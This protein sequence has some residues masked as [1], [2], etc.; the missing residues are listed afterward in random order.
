VVKGIHLITL[1]YTDPQGRPRPINYR[2]YDFDHGYALI[3]LFGE[4]AVQ[5]RGFPGT[6]KAGQH[7]DGNAGIGGIH[8]HGRGT[9][10]L[11]E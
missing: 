6:D 3:V 10:C 5:E 8:G 9:G 11:G 4:N 7:R 2:I 1:C